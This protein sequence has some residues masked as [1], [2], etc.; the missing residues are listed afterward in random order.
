M[1][2]NNQNYIVNR[3]RDLRYSPTQNQLYQ[4]PV[5]E[6]QGYSN[7]NSTNLYGHWQKDWDDMGAIEKVGSILSVGSAMSAGVARALVDGDGTVA[8]NVWNTITM[9][10]RRTFVDLLQEHNVGWA[11][12]LGTVLD[13]GLDPFTWLPGPVGVFKTLAKKTGTDI[14][15]KAGKDA[16]LKIEPISRFAN[17]IGEPLTKITNNLGEKFNFYHGTDK[18]LF[19]TLLMKKYGMTQELIDHMNEW[20]S[21]AKSISPDMAKRMSLYKAG[22]PVNTKDFIN[23]TDILSKWD[24]LTTKA[25]NMKLITP[26]V[27]AS[28]T[29]NG[30]SQYLPQVTKGWLSDGWSL[31]KSLMGPTALPGFAMDRK[32]KIADKDFIPFMSE[33]S[34]GLQ[35]VAKTA[36]PG[37][38]LNEATNV[39]A[40]MNPNNPYRKQFLGYV[41]NAITGHS[42]NIASVRKHLHNQGEWFKPIDSLVDL[43]K[44]YESDLI[45]TA[46]KRGVEEYVFRSADSAKNGW[47]EKLLP[48]TDLTGKKLVTSAHDIKS[49]IS[50]IKALD[51]PGLYKNLTHELGN[52]AAHNNPLLND[53]AVLEGPLAKQLQAATTRLGIPSTR[54]TYVVGDS[55]ANT[56]SRIKDLT[57][58]TGPKSGALLQFYDK[59]LKHWSKNATITRLPF[60][61]RNFVSN[62]ALNFLS[63][64]EPW[65]IAQDSVKAG[66]IQ[67]GGD[68]IVKVGKLS[69]TASEWRS[70][71]GGLG[72]R[73]YGQISD[74]MDKNFVD[75]TLML[76][77]G[78]TPTTIVGK[79]LDAVYGVGE[80]FGQVIE[81]NG[82]ITCAINR[83]GKNGG[84]LEEAATHTWKYMIQYD[85][86]T[87][88]EKNV[89]KRVI[90]FYAWMRKNYPLQVGEFVKSVAG[91]EVGMKRLAETRQ[92]SMFK[93]YDGIFGHANPETKDED[94]FKPEYM[95]DLAYWKLPDNVKNTFAKITGREMK[96][97]VYVNVDLPGNALADL[98]KGPVGMLQK[99]VSSLSPVAL[100]I[101]LGLNVTNFPEPNTPI[102]RFKG[103]LKPAPWPMA[104]LPEPTWGFLGLQPMRDPKTGREILGAP[105]KATQALFGAFPAMM[106]FHKMFPQ[107]KAYLEQE[108]A[109]WRVLKYATGINFTPVDKEQERYYWAIQKENR[110]NDLI[111]LMVQK[112]GALSTQEIKEYL[113]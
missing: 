29:V 5:M 84:D 77:Q 76:M 99:M 105:A 106:E 30:L 16:F 78:K 86:I 97:N 8:G 43:G 14:A 48:T 15:L 46:H 70:L 72:V 49:T 41:N 38:M 108:S 113:K 4:V 88:W 56:L 94:R 57:D 34:E 32:F 33:L 11:P 59:T 6:Q 111:K 62:T 68:Q 26:Q 87:P 45:K 35:T 36:S 9:K 107:S 91:T 104:F 79:T 73:G 28:H 51:K 83:L 52:W 92:A 21:L 13:V 55:I 110:L 101:Q 22:A 2:I 95:N 90:P 47:A 69:K 103:E 24:D 7:P 71:L 40:R 17:A 75:A 37:D 44:V 85:Q 19:D 12:I 10:D 112:G 42:G 1:A 82:R 74:V 93:A 66:I 27:V 60:H 81:D 18:Q 64:V 50:V 63:G 109:P 67:H 98:A 53:L 39:V 96:H 23:Y 65:E 58:H 80:K 3:D 31:G 25:L 61:M 100:P 20:N 89:A 102:E 54:N